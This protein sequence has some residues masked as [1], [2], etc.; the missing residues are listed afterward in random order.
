MYCLKPSTPSPLVILDR[1]ALTPNPRSVSLAL[2]SRHV[3]G[4]LESPAKGVN[5]GGTSPP[6]CPAAPEGWG[7]TPR[8]R[9]GAPLTEADGHASV[10]HCGA[11]S[12]RL[13]MSENGNATQTPPNGERVSPGTRIGTLL[14]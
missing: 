3:Q 11:Y 13:V 7:P 10:D 5:A 6:A 14:C 12:L 8:R 1:C 4:A 2:L 9:T